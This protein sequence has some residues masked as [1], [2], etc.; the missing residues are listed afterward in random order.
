[1]KKKILVLD[2]D[3]HIAKY[4]MNV[5]N[6]NGYEAY[7]APDGLA[8]LEA[9]KKNPPDL[10]TLDLDMPEAAGPKFFRE[11]TKDEAFK[12]IPVIVIS[13]LPAPERS[14]K[15]VVAAVSK[16]FDPDKLLAIVKKTLG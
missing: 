6:D 16:P 3:A 12:E 13:G 11:M 5:F 4:L 10:I 9:M 15:K 7:S 2:D 8:G 1:M 14:L